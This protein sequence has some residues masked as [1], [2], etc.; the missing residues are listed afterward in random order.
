MPWNEPV[1]LLNEK[2]VVRQSR[3]HQSRSASASCRAESPRCVLSALPVLNPHA[4]SFSSSFG[5]DMQMTILGFIFSRST[6]STGMDGGSAGKPGEGPPADME[7]HNGLSPS[8]NDAGGTD[9]NPAIFADDPF[10]APCEWGAAP[11]MKHRLPVILARESQQSHA[12]KPMPSEPRRHVW[13]RQG[14]RLSKT[15]PPNR[16]HSFLC[17]L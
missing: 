1:S 9:S 6:E 12:A 11:N 7:S 16:L 4:G 5:A 10:H 15:R 3:Y 8:P 14:I 2:M 13:R 17:T